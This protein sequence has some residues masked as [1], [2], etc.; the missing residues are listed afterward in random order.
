MENSSGRSEVIWRKK[1]VSIVPFT[2][3]CPPLFFIVI[4]GKAPLLYKSKGRIMYPTSQKAGLTGLY[5]K[6]IV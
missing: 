1:Y 6:V 5:K 3:T 4:P 2:F